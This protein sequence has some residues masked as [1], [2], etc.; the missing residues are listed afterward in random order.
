[1]KLTAEERS[2][3]NKQNASHSRGPTTEARTFSFRLPVAG[4]RGIQVR[5][6]V[7]HS[8]RPIATK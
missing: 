3:I 1:M 5:A 4:T 7:S 8:R 2:R 6:T